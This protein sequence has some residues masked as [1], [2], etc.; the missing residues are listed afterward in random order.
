M[1]ERDGVPS[2]SHALGASARPRPFVSASSSRFSVALGA[3]RVALSRLL[4]ASSLGLL[5]R[6]VP[7][8]GY[9][10]KVEEVH[11]RGA[12]GDESRGNE[13][14]ARQPL[15]ARDPREGEG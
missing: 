15:A 3:L 13:G 10:V 7:T 6:R 12:D 8:G 9:V 1:S 2:V 14:A 5:S 4:L 11:A